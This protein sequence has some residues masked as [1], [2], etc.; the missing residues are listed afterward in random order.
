MG[1]VPGQDPIPR[2][3]PPLLNEEPVPP[4]VDDLTEDIDAIEERARR[5][6]PAEVERADRQADAVEGDRE[7]EEPGAERDGVEP[8]ARSDAANDPTTD[9]PDADTPT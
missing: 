3:G 6:G 5:S 8:G 7:H 2:S 9:E 4:G 1:I